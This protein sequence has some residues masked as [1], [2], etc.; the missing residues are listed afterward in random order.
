MA[1][2]TTSNTDVLT[3]SELW[4]NML[5]K[6]LEEDLNAMQY[7]NWIDFPD[8]NTMTIPSIGTLDASDYVEDT[9]I[10]YTPM[11]TGEF[12]F[13]ITQLRRT[14]VIDYSQCITCKELFMRCFY[15]IGKDGSICNKG[16]NEFIVKC[17]VP[18]II[19]KLNC[20]IIWRNH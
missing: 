16:V 8:G 5:K 2:M 19:P 14:I 3:R 1:G 15:F 10:E 9:A 11:D 17:N 13:S 20:F 18:N 6:V 12:Q 4:S 7:V